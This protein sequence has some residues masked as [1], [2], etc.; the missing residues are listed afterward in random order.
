MRLVA[1]CLVALALVA[2]YD[3]VAHSGRY[4]SGVGKMLGHMTSVS[5]LR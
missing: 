3:H 5:W 4:W 2:A 1:G